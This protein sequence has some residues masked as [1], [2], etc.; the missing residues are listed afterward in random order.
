VHACGKD[1]EMAHALH[2]AAITRIGD[3]TTHASAKSPNFKPECAWV[4]NGAVTGDCCSGGGL[5]RRFENGS[6]Q[7]MGASGRGLAEAL[8]SQRAAEEKA[9]IKCRRR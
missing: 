6:L 9:E 8:L 3:H 2:P 4:A 1:I 7:W 5:E